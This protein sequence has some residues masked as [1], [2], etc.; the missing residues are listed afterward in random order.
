[1]TVAE[2]IVAIDRRRNWIAC[3]G[4]WFIRI[5]ESGAFEGR[6]GDNAWRPIAFVMVDQ[7]RDRCTIIK[8]VAS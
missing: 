8:A 5:T 2:A 7:L 1:M 4:S 3:S 6:F